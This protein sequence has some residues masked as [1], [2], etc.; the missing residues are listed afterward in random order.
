MNLKLVALMAVPLVGVRFAHSASPSIWLAGALWLS[1]SFAIFVGINMLR[2]HSVP[3]HGALLVA[4]GAVMNGVVIL[5]NGGVMPVH[6][7]A[8]ETANGAWRS[9]DHGGHLLFL[10]DYMAL[11]GASPG[12]LLVFAGLVITFALMAR[13]GLQVLSYRR[14]LVAP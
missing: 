14:S 3:I 5:A 11:G 9:A 7:M 12:D 2:R 10:G 1:A 13:R 6:G 8:A 4:A